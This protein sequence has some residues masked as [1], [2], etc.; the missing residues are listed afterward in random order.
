MAELP[1][2]FDFEVHNDSLEA[3]DHDIAPS[4]EEEPIVILPG[5]SFVPLFIITSSFMF[6][7]KFVLI[8]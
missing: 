2:N 1:S 5:M 3:L 8:I 6:F 4:T 7:Y